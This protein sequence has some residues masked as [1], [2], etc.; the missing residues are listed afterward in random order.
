[1]VKEVNVVGR[2]IAKQ[3]LENLAKVESHYCRASTTKQY[4]EPQ[5]N[6]KSELHRIFLDALQRKSIETSFTTSTCRRIQ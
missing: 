2:T 1:M 3:F 4:L 6:P 5:I